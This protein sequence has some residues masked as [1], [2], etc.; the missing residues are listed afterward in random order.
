M[1]LRLYPLVLHEPTFTI[2]YV[3]QSLLR[4]KSTSSFTGAGVQRLFRPF[5]GDFDRPFFGDLPPFFFAIASRSR[6]FRCLQ[7]TDHL[8]SPFRNRELTRICGC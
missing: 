8:I 5:F 6:L 3:S 7:R 1:R 4:S 2:T